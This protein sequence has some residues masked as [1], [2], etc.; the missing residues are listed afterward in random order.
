MED[1]H[2]RSIPTYLRTAKI[3]AH[4]SRVFH[5]VDE[6]RVACPHH[7]VQSNQFHVEDNNLQFWSP[8]GVNHG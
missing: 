2:C 3:F 4:C 8:P 1:G 5:K 7:Q 6:G